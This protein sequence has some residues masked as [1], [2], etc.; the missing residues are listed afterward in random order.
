[1]A[2]F[3]PR[4][5]SSAEINMSADR[6]W[7][8][9]FI[10]LGVA[11]LIGLAGIMAIRDLVGGGSVAR[12]ALRKVPGARGEIEALIAIAIVDDP[13]QSPRANP[14]GLGAGPAPRSASIVGPGK[15]LYRG[16]M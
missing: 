6:R 11:L 15:V 9:F 3:V 7:L 5:D 16:A 12:E 2:A 1:M 14:G 8:L 4:V 13:L 10:V